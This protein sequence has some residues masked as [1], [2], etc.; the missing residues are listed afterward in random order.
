[1]ASRCS[2]WLV[3]RN[4]SMLVTTAR[5]SMHPS[6]P[7]LGCT[8]TGV[9][10]CSLR[11]IQFRECA[12]L[13]SGCVT[14][15]AMHSTSHCSILV[16]ARRLL[17]FRCFL[18]ALLLACGT[19][20]TRPRVGCSSSLQQG[21]QSSSGARV[22]QAPP[23]HARS[24]HWTSMRLMLPPDAKCWLRLHVLSTLALLICFLTGSWLCSTQT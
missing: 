13:T 11:C 22:E 18:W 5:R 8:W 9:G 6:R 23:W 7:Y 10:R 1:M 14:P 2:E 16:P 17:L 3:V 4:V 19:P 24:S 12:P 21:T 15:K 20:E